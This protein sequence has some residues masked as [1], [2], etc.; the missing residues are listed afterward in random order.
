MTTVPI[1]YAGPWAG[2]LAV[3]GAPAKW[4]DIRVDATGVRVR[5]SVMFRTRF[6]RAAVA[7]VVPHRAVVSIGAHG[8][9]G[10]WLVNGAHKPIATIILRQPV[11]ARVLGFRVQLRELMVSVDDVAGLERLLVT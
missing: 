8:W 4:S 5:M 9:K 11:P 10:R 2:L 6:D 3:V 7:A 1:K